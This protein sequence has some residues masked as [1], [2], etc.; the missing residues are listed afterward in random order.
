M[1]NLDT[2]N[3]KQSLEIRQELTEI[4]LDFLSYSITYDE[5][6][7]KLENIQEEGG[8][9][10]TELLIC[11]DIINNTGQMENHPITITKDEFEHLYRYMIFLQTSPSLNCEKRI[12]FSFFNL[13]SLLLLAIYPFI[14]SSVL[15]TCIFQ[16]F[17]CFFRPLRNGVVSG[18]PA[19]Y[20]YRPFKSKEDWEKHK[21]MINNEKYNFHY[22][23][24]AFH[25]CENF[26]SHLWSISLFFLLAP[27]FLLLNAL[28]DREK[29]YIR[30]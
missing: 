23:A 9:R 8:E 18:I 30:K 16:I 10:T 14:W 20:K 15:Y 26:K 6:I 12:T 17:L 24:D 5:F 29:Y 25:E 3:N 19:A 4:L 27:F 11:E 22:N 7:E 2:M 1:G 28:P 21:H 13:L